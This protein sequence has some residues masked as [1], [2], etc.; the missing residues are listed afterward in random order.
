MDPIPIEPQ[1]TW[2]L[3]ADYRGG[4]NKKNSLLTV[5]LTGS[6]F[7]IGQ[8]TSSI[9]GQE[10]LELLDNVSWDANTGLLEFR[11]SGPDFSPF[12]EWYRGTIVEGVFV[13]RFSHSQQSDSRPDP[14]AFRF[15]VTGWNSTFLDGD[16]VP[17]SY[18]VTIDK[19]RRARLRLDRLPPGHV[20][21]SPTEQFVGRLKVYSTGSGGDGEEPE[22]DLEVTRWD[23]QILNFIRYVPG[24]TQVFTGTASGRDI[25]GYYTQ[26]ETNEGGSWS[27]TGMGSLAMALSRRRR[28][29]DRRGRI[30]PEPP[31]F[32]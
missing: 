22:Y 12:W 3:N 23:G 21:H 1:G 11:R 2:Y 16:F 13:G 7:L 32:T 28:R 25:S 9:N 8:V 31:Y 10:T 24:G 26:R 14:L 15:H 6:N 29:G 20:D 18:D 5:T 4:T 27:G 17:R 30:V 19:N